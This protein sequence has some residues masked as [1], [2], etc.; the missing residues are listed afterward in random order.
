MKTRMEAPILHHVDATI[1]RKFEK[2]KLITERL[3]ID[4]DMER[5]LDKEIKETI[6]NLSEYCKVID[7][8]RYRICCTE[9]IE[10]YYNN[11]ETHYSGIYESD[12][13]T[14]MLAYAVII[15]DIIEN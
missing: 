10:K 7:V 14:Y 13:F 6:K 11:Y 5:E 9:N 15:Y 8:K 1:I 3:V 12:K 2:G 4:H